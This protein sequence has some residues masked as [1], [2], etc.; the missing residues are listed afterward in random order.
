MPE[1]SHLTQEQEIKIMHTHLIT[2]CGIELTDS[3]YAEP[4]KW[5]SEKKIVDHKKPG[6]L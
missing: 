4:W 5:N 2:V 3:L 6:P 1:Y